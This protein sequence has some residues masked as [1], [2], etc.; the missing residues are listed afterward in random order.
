M[1]KNFTLATID[2]SQMSPQKM[3]DTFVSNLTIG[4]MPSSV[5]GSAQSETHIPMLNKQSNPK[6]DSAKKALPFNPDNMSKHSLAGRKEVGAK[7][8]DTID[9]MRQTSESLM[10]QQ[11]N[12]DSEAHISSVGGTFKMLDANAIIFP[13]MHIWDENEKIDS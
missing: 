7:I 3:R 11:L 1:K 6:V 9:K 2:K 12:T 8:K 5:D 4:N 10:K 13:G